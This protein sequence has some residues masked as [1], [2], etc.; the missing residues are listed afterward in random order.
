M[1]NW[2]PGKLMNLSIMRDKFLHIP[3]IATYFFG[4]AKKW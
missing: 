1:V 2:I 3:H 4:E